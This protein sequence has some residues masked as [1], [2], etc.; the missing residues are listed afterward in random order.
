MHS[1]CPFCARPW[2]E[3]EQV[4]EDHT[5]PASFGG[6]ETVR[7]CKPCNDVL[8]GGIEAA[9]LGAHSVFTMLSQS[10]GWTTGALWSRTDDGG[11][12]RLNFGTGEHYATEPRAKVVREDARTKSIEVTLPPHLMGAGVDHPYVQHLIRQHGGDPSQS[13]V[14][15]RRPAPPETF[16]VDATNHISDLRRIVAKIALCCGTKHWGDGFVLSSLADR[17]RVI[18]DA[19][20]DWPAAIR[21][22]TPDDPQAR[23]QWPLREEERDPLLEQ[24]ERVLP[25]I[26]RRASADQPVVGQ[27]DLGP[28]LVIFTPCGGGEQTLIAVHALGFL[29]PVL[30]VDA[31]LPP[32]HRSKAEVIFPKVK[33]ARPS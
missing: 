33:T 20:A 14:T 15:N 32:G 2:N 25:L 10:Q 7:A 6:A 9:L 5:V 13:T 17:L 1:I 16:Y 26:L 31:P 27:V 23:A 29:L 28:T 12:A 24:I 21:V 18:L 4:S 22:P 30:G 11:K 8:G 3:V 19:R